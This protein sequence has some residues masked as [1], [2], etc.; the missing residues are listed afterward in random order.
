[1]TEYKPKNKRRSRRFRQHKRRRMPINVAAS[2]ITTF[3]VYCGIASILAAIRADYDVAS[4]WILAA[5]ISDMLDGMIARLTKSVSD[6]G[7]ELDSMAD[8]V[9][10]GGAPAVLIY[11]AYLRESDASGA[12]TAPMGSMVATLFVICTALRLARYNIFQSERQDV[13]I[14]LPSPAAAG[15]IA[16]FT[17]FARYF[18]LNVA[19]WVLGPLTIALAGLMVSTVRYPRKTMQ[20]FVLA[21]RKAFRFLVL[22]VV[23][24]S[25]FNYA[26]Q[27]SPAIVLLP[28]GMAYVLFGSVNELYVF[29]RRRKLVPSLGASEEESK[30]EAA[31]QK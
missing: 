27:Y 12:Y 7:K 31:S 22:C 13:F 28:L 23:G 6:F 29:L 5:I 9:A 17:L 16:S 15:N 24:I 1:M 19:Y 25:V 2:V 21:P 4:Y 26:L 3:S 8:M 10:F 14:G 18:E 11:S 30:T 20:V